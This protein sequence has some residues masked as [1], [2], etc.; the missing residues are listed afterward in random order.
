MGGSRMHHQPI[1]Q[2]DIDQ[3]SITSG[4][5]ATTETESDEI[6]TQL[7][8]LALQS[9]ANSSSLKSIED[10]DAHSIVHSGVS[11]LSHV[12]TPPGK[13]GFMNVLCEQ[14][15]IQWMQAKI[16]HNQDKPQFE[17]ALQHHQMLFVVVLSILQVYAQIL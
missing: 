11:V 8:L 4:Q 1:N 5:S 13:S 14:N 10:D 12:N 9:L 17:Q 7:T 15:S 16:I 3:V 2:M 6:Q